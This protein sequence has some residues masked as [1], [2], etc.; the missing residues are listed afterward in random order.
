[1]IV[2]KLLM[3]RILKKTTHNSYFQQFPLWCKTTCGFTM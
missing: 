2:E 1:M 3:N